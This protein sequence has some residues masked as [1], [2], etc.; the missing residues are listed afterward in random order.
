MLV[1]ICIGLDFQGRGR[2]S[3]ERGSAWGKGGSRGVWT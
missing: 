3:L 2:E 1:C